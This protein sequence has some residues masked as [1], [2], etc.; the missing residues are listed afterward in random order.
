[1]SYLTIRNF[2]IVSNFKF[3]MD[4]STGT[5]ADCTSLGIS[6]ELFSFVPDLVIFWLY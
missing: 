4:F 3:F 5:P 2:D 1:M 6:K